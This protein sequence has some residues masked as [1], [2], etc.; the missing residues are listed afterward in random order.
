MTSRRTLHTTLSVLLLAGSLSCSGRP[1]PS[2]SKSAEPSVPVVQVATPADETLAIAITAP[3][4]F[5]AYEEATISTETPGTVAEIRVREGDRVQQG[6][7]LLVLDP[8][9]ARLAVK[10]A[11]AA[12]AQAQANFEK[13]RSELERKQLL[14]SD[15][16][17][18]QGTFDTF[19]AQHDAA[20][21]AVDGAQS[22]LALARQSLEDMTITAPFAGVIQAKE[23][24]VGEYVRPGDRL[25][26][27]IQIDPLKLRFEV[28]EK[29]AARLAVG[30][31][32]TTAVSAL[33]GET[34]EGDIMTVF[35]TLDVH[36]RTIR[37]EAKVPNRDHR[38]KPGFYASVQVPLARVPGSLVIPRSA[39]VRREGI[40]QVLVVRDDHAQAVTVV[41]GAET[42][43][44][45]SVVS[46]LSP[47]DRLIV[48]GAEGL[49][50][51][52]PVRVAQ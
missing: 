47:S 9:K 43:D 31:A 26:E 49:Q 50:S 48:T 23:T 35:P 27:V 7:T 42:A 51:G 45:I 13:A 46:G 1:A 5:V 44:Q 24:S 40:E 16:T 21:A 52:D 19:K 33:P 22:S 36:S 34:F 8:T 3:G 32:V 38:L 37:V 39:L 17:I 25:L 20:V 15:R 28:P 12:L 11:E 18:S 10:Q 4:S 29:H 30:Q 2:E 6:A 41:V 14:L